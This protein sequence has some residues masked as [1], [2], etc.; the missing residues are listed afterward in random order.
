MKALLLLALIPTFAMAQ[1]S[2][3][4]NELI[5]VSQGTKDSTLI[6]L[7]FV[8]RTNAASIDFEVE[9]GT[10]DASAVDLSNCMVGKLVVG[11]MAACKL[12]GTKVRGVLVSPD[13]KALPAGPV[14]LGT[15]S[16]RGSNKQVS[17][18][19]WETDDVAGKELSSKVTAD[20]K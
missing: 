5:A 2:E 14:S 1:A 9:V 16:V 13:L 12:L 4:N 6:A 18:V 7:D 11:K 15:I 10:A 17:V 19:R 3:Q 20:S 8:N